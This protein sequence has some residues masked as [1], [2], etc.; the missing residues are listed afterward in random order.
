MS[1][2]RPV[3]LESKTLSGARR[4][5]AARRTSRTSGH[6]AG[7]S[8]TTTWSCWRARVG[9]WVAPGGLIRAPR[10]ASVCPLGDHSSRRRSLRL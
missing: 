10:H 6:F 7:R 8:G 3:R 5:S 4:G 1:V 9:H 2:D